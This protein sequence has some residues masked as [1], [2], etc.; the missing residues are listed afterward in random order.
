M[1][2]WLSPIFVSSGS[3][4]ADHDE[5]PP[6]RGERIM[7]RLASAELVARLLRNRERAS[8]AGTVILLSAQGA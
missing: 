2:R 6:S 1:N 4:H 3:G 7:P 8:K 5:V